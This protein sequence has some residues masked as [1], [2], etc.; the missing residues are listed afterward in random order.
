MY[1]NKTKD[2]KKGIRY[3]ISWRRCLRNIL[4][5]INNDYIQVENKHFMY[6]GS[7]LA[8]YLKYFTLVR[9]LNCYYIMTRRQ[10]NDDCIA[11][12][13]DLR[14]SEIVFMGEH[15]GSLY[16]SKKFL[17]FLQIRY[18]QSI[19]NGDCN[20]KVVYIYGSN[21]DKDTLDTHKKD[22]QL[23][24][25]QFKTCKVPNFINDGYTYSKCFNGGSWPSHKIEGL[26]GLKSAKAYS[27]DDTFSN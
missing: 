25:V 15:K 21:L 8:Y 7:Q 26:D 19:N 27:Q 6:Q 10:E 18:R 13:I 20:L 2:F 23:G 12:I 11:K 3:E 22:H 16:S 9:I 14:Y 5:S 1:Y 17:E 4:K 24:K